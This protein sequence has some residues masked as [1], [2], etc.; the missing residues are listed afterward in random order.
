MKPSPLQTASMGVLQAPEALKKFQLHRFP[1]DD[2]LVQFVKHHWIVSWD[3][4]DHE[5]FCQDVI[6]NPCVNLVAESS[7]SAVYGVPSRKYTKRLSGRGRAYGVKFRPGGFYP[8]V[9]TPMS[10]LTDGSLSFEEAFRS[11]SVEL[12]D[13]LRSGEPPERLIQ[14][15]E[16]L[17]IERLPEPDPA[18]E[19]LNAIID[20]IQA[21][22]EVS[23][24]EQTSKTFGIGVR[25]LQRLFSKYV[26]VSPKWVIQLYRLQNAAETLDK[27]YGGSP[28]A[29]GAE[30]GF[31]D[32][33]HFIKSFKTMI[34]KT[35][36]D[37]S[38]VSGQTK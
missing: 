17:L 19:L 26:G 28:A 25:T 11:G 12:T 15:T 22:R 18:V 13:A 5:L 27:G 21:N 4:P 1:P 30:L 6:P 14:L 3:L 35:P 8:Y 16:R 31:Y 23:S 24:V 2:R 37:Y 20:Y 9:S 32:Q 7:G 36:E 29:L 34:G 10:R 38:G 33:S